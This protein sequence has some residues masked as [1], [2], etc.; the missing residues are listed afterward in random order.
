[1]IALRITLS[2]LAVLVLMWGLARLGRG[3]LARRGAVGGLSV[4]ARQQL[5]RNAAVVVVRL[6]GRGLL[7]GVTDQQV[8]LLGEA[9]VAELEVATE[10]VRHRTGPA[11]TRSPASP[12]SGP[13]RSTVDAAAKRSTV[14]SGPLAGSVLSRRTW[15]QLLEFLRERTARQ[16]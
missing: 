13:E 2:L 8:R 5:S 9:D 10:P 12:G 6:A 16:P 4:V 15:G 14:D 3:P 7:L 1:M 11:R